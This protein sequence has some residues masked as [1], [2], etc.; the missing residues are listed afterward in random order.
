MRNNR[1][2][3]RS[4]KICHID[5]FLLNWIAM[6][7]AHYFTFSCNNLFQYSFGRTLTWFILCFTKSQWLA[8][9][10]RNDERCFE[11]K[12]YQNLKRETERG[13]DDHFSGEYSGE[14]NSFLGI[15]TF[16]FYFRHIC[17]FGRCFVFLSYKEL[18][19]SDSCI[20][21]LVETKRRISTTC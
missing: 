20:L 3:A 2:L 18:Q 21:W 17:N 13:Y 15:F 6:I 14:K 8:S 11:W 9:I 19:I 5:W 1:E 4:L 16:L 7:C 12:P 10:W